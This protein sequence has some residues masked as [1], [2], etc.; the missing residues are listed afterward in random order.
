MFEYEYIKVFVNVQDIWR[1]WWRSSLVTHRISE[2]SEKK[3]NNES[4]SPNI[5]GNTLLF[6]TSWMQGGRAHP[7]SSLSRA[8][9]VFVVMLC[10]KKGRKV[11]V[12]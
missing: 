2:C 10:L 5:H 8:E 11:S 3:S 7:V 1:K 9:A 12:L 4:L 6:Q